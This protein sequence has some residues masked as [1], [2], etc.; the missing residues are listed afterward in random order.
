MGHDNKAP[1]AAACYDHPVSAWAPLAVLAAASVSP[2]AWDYAVTAGPAARELAVEVRF[3][4]AV[5]SALTFD[6]GMGAFVDGFEVARGTQWTSVPANG[7]LFVAPACERGPCRVR[8]RVRLLDAARTLERRGVAHTNGDVVLAPPSSWLAQPLRDARP[9]RYRFRVS[10]PAGVS[11]ATGVF[12][13]D[14]DGAYE[15][16]TEDLAQA[17]YSAFGPLDH[18]R[19]DAPG[20]VVD[21]AMAAGG[22][23]IPKQDVLDWVE[24]SARAVAG[25]YGA[26]PLPRAQVIVLPGGRRPVGFG[27]TL[28][29]GGASIIVWLGPSASRAHLERD[30]VLVHE[31]T[32][33]GF[34]NVPRAQ[35]WMEEGLATY[36]EPIARARAGLL[37]EAEVWRG[38]VHGLP[39]GQPRADENGFDRTHR[40]G[41]LYWGG[42]LYWFLA[43]LAIR[44]RTAGRRS[45]D[46]ALRAIRSQGGTIAVRWP[47]QRT[48]ETGD[49]ATGTDVLRTL[50]ARLGTEGSTPIDLEATW[51][52]L[53][54]RAE[55]DGVRFDDAAP[56]AALRRAI[57]SGRE[58][59]ATGRTE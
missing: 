6:G 37:A 33:L 52:R 39:N 44:E 27:T 28:G 34:P 40:W 12:P 46:D 8:Y 41:A 10:L 7:D 50:Y 29:N 24:R 26:F 35:H 23:S 42:A 16:T 20:A 49:R 36:V 53:G 47:L 19:V 22:V 13:A 25:Y 56:L 58:S 30:W 31:M 55:A 43:D 48:L 32:H 2:P 21:V 15:A 11:F 57:T 5:G 18:L 1:S 3:G 9:G 17:P 59:A 54:V 38:L 14:G 4:R 51:T 45:V